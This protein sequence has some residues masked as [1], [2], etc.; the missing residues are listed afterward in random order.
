MDKERKTFLKK[1]I[2]N[3]IAVIISALLI[4]NTIFILM[5]GW[6]NSKMF[7][8][9]F[10]FGL[11]LFVLLHDYLLNKRK[12][13]AH[14][15]MGLFLVFLLSFVIIE[16]LVIYGSNQ[17]AESGDAIIVLGAGLSGYN[18]GPLLRRRLDKAY[19]F[20]VSN[21]E[22][23]C[24]VSGGQGAD[25]KDS[26]ANVMAEYLI[27]KGI[28]EE[29]IIREDKATNTV[30]N[31]A[32]SKDILDDYFGS[33]E[34]KTVYVTNTFHVYRSGLIAKKAGLDTEGLSAP[35]LKTSEINYFLREYCSLIFYWLFR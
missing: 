3:I 32:F 9:L 33:S 26:E 8:G 27:S 7:S 1:S 4:F 30:E 24:I 11:L 25:E 6:D 34:Y 19:E 28:A 16:G 29:R 23:I 22:A 21:D 12:W 15:I 20:L 13:M 31:F 17:K 5:T 35:S 10:G 2:F 14:I 18:P